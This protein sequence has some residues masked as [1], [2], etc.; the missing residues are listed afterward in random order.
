VRGVREA[1]DRPESGENRRAIDST[2]AE[3]DRMGR[4]EGIDAARV[5]MLRSMADALDR[6]PWNSQMWKVYGEALGEL[7]ASG[8]DDDAIQ[9]VIDE[10]QSSSGDA[11]AS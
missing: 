11:E 2:L 8:D 1:V 7:T 6:K 10:L 5:Q 4:L 9:A 3:L